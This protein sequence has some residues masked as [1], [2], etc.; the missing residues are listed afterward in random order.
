MWS[1]RLERFARGNWT[2][3][4]FCQKE[5]I[6]VPSFY[7]WRR[8]LAQAPGSKRRGEV[9]SPPPRRPAFVPV[10]IVPQ[11]AVEIYLPNGV[12]VCV[13]AGDAQ[14]LGAAIVAAG[15]LPRREEDAAC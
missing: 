5:G 2:V 15:Q 4:A 3:A 9:A 7:E 11:A 14:A 13:P 12:R 8:R 10:T 1:E 6:S